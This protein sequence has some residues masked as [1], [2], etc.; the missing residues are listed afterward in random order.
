MA[1]SSCYFIIRACL[2]RSTSPSTR[3]ANL[4]LSLSGSGI[5]VTVE[6]LGSVFSDGGVFLSS[7]LVG[8]VSFLSVVVLASL[9]VVLLEESEVVDL[10]LVVSS[11]SSFVFAGTFFVGVFFGGLGSRS[12]L[13]LF[14]SIQIYIL[15]VPLKISF[16]T[17]IT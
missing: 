10:S 6:A 16:A 15:N 12:L 14:F 1:I 8:E 3:E 4:S 2:A 5:T 7:L 13:A 9:S 11:F 17:P